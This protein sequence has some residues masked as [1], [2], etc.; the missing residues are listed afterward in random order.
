MLIL[1]KNDNFDLTPYRMIV[2]DKDCYKLHR[3]LWTHDVKYD[4]NT[5]WD[6]IHKEIKFSNEKIKLG[7]DIIY[8]AQKISN[9][10]QTVY[11]PSMMLLGAVVGQILLMIPADSYF[12]PPLFIIF[13]SLFFL[14][15]MHLR[16]NYHRVKLND[17]IAILDESKFSFGIYSY[18]FYYLVKK[19]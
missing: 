10:L 3:Y 5:P 16:N 12:K 11:K 7:F 6:E 8:D 13:S 19:V 1:K 2:L 9:C 14:L 15:L 18:K 4:E 17:C